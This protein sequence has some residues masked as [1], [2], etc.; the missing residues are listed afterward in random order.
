MIRTSVNIGGR[1]ISDHDFTS[2]SLDQRMG[3]HHTFEIRFRQDAKKSILLEKT[4][5]WVGQTISLGFDNHKDIELDA[6]PVKDL[7]EGVVTSIELSRAH[8]WGELVVKGHSPT[9]L[10]DDGPNTQS[11]SDA[12][13][14]EIVD[15]VI[16]PYKKFFPQAPLVSP[17]NQVNSIEYTVQ[18]QENAFTFLK[19]LSNQYG[20]WFFYDGLRMF[21][22]KPPN[23]KPI[24]L[25]FGAYGLRYFDIALETAPMDLEVKGYDYRS[26]KSISAEAKVNKS[27][28]EFGEEIRKRSK[29]IYP[30]KATGNIFVNTEQSELKQIAVLKAKAATEAMVVLSGASENSS[31]VPGAI[32]DIEDKSLRE[33]FGKYRVISVNHSIGQGGDYS[34]NFQAIPE[35]IDVPPLSGSPDAPFCDTKVG[36]VIHVDDPDEMGR[37]KVA[38]KWQE[39]ETTPWIR[40]AS[41]YTGSDKG[42]YMIPEVGDQVLVA[43]EDSNPSKPYVLTGMYHGKASPEFYSP[44]NDFKGFKSRE[45]NTWLFND[46]EK[47]ILLSAP[48]RLDLHAGKEINL[49]TDGAAPSSINLDVGDGT[50]TIKAKKIVIEATDEISLDGKNTIEINSGDKLKIK[51]GTDLKQEAVN[52]TSK[53][54]M[55]MENSGTEL[56]LKGNAK[57]VLKGGIVQI[58]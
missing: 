16:H 42:F 3:G 9:I 53:A 38:L 24:K 49:R 57:V 47:S 11:F 7:F 36:K 44:N 46:A 31:L 21:F 58:N 8:G 48:Q 19:R 41:P 40:V 14:Q 23:E 4:R 54:D 34:N 55:K 5:A 28:N 6:I 51:A 15:K 45:K 43:F 13:L 52:I 10:L 1:R 26:D 12:G 30:N 17:S 32:I 29:Q 27:T 37:V 56:D 35:E 2:V 50:V 39:D 22:G 20:E 33:N 18:Y 25:D